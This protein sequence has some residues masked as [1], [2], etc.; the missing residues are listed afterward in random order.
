MNCSTPRFNILYQK[1][2]TPK[3]E[4]TSSEMTT[5]ILSINPPKK[6]KKKKLKEYGETDAFTCRLSFTIKIDEMVIEYLDTVL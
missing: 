2:E 4:I 6:I 1:R 5:Q 3:N